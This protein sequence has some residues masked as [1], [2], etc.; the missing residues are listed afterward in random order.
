MEASPR[1]SLNYVNLTLQCRCSRRSESKY[2]GCW[3]RSRTLRD[4]DVTTYWSAH[5]Q[6]QSK[7]HVG[8][9][10]VLHCVDEEEDELALKE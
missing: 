2:H 8:G 6:I 9:G 10:E 4:G 5:P 7:S 3:S 1:P